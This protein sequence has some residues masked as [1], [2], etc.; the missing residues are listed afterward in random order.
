M[1]KIGDL[2]VGTKIK[3]LNSTYGWDGVKAGDIGEIIGKDKD[4]V[5]NFATYHL[6]RWFIKSNVLEGEYFEVIGIDSEKPMSLT[7]MSNA[8]YLCERCTTEKFGR[9][10]ICE[11]S[12]CEKAYES[13][14]ADYEDNQKEDKKMEK[15]IKAVVGVGYAYIRLMKELLSEK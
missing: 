3:I 13:Y 12:Y 9:L 15:G 11:I 8:G 4:T 14:L 7:E 1:R 5:I 10:G 2:E 6:D